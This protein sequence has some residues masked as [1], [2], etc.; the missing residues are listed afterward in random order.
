MLDLRSCWIVF[1]HIVRGCPGGLLQ[2]SEGEAVMILLASVS[3]DILAMWPNVLGQQKMVYNR[4][5]AVLTM[6]VRLD[7]CRSDGAC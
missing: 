7:L 4:L 3:S 1:I 2:S 5:K 6:I